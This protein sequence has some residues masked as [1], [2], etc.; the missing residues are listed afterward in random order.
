MVRRD[1]T[2]ATLLDL[3]AKL[4]EV[5]SLTKEEIYSAVVSTASMYAGLFKD[6]LALVGPEKAFALNWKQGEVSGN[7]LAGMLREKLG[8]KK[9]E[10]ETIVAVRKL[11]FDGMGFEW[12]VDVSPK[13]V[14]FKITK[15]PFYDGFRAAGM[16][17]QTLRKMCETMGGGEYSALKKHYPNIDVANEIRSS[18]K[19]TCIEEFKIL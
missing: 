10:A 13:S 16:D 5:C 15:C 3:P 11:M 12:G 14:R 9:L 8:N 19:A 4:L 2:W 1:C 6:V 18:A 7:G 17:E